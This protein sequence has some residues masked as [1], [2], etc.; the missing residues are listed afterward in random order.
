MKELAESRISIDPNICSGKPCIKG[1]RV[2]VADILMALAEGLDEKEIL[3]NFRQVR[4]EDIRA[5]IAYAYCLADNVKMRITAAGGSMAEVEN[6]VAGA[7]ELQRQAQE[8]FSKQLE[9][10]AQKQE[11][12]TQ[13]RVSQ[14]K[15]KKEIERGPKLE[16]PPKRDYD[17]EIELEDD[18]DIQVF[19]DADEFE[20][21]L[22]MDR[23][24]YIFEMRDD[25]AYWLIYSMKDDVEID[26]AMK[27]NI[28]LFYNDKEAIFEGYLSTDRLHKVFIQKDE[29]G[30]TRGRVL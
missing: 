17:L 10:Q 16:T 8:V 14:L 24:N 13:E 15:A 9:E 28:K 2:Q 3:R 22:Q 26:K 19:T 21:G 7:E 23:D 18:S 25:D 27:R 4:K 6:D 29:E 30:N 5:T 20:Q 1:T 11:E 12:I